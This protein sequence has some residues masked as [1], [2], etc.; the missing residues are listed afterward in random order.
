MTALRTTAA[1]ILLAVLTWET[2]SAAAITWSGLTWN[3]KS[4]T[5][6]GPGP[7]TWSAD[8]VFV[9]ASGDLHLAITSVGGSWTC[10]EIATTAAF[11]F[12]SY[13]WQV[14]TAVDNLDPN[15]VLGLFAYGP[16]ALGPDGTHEID[17]EYARFGS[18]DADNGRWTDWPN[19]IVTPSLV[20]RSSYPLQLGADPTT[21][22]RFTWAPTDI[23]FST[24]AGFQPP[25]ANASLIRSWTYRPDDP[26]QTISQ[27]PMPVHVNLWLNQGAPPT[28]GQGVEVVIHAFSF[29]PAPA[30]SVP[31][32]PGD[33]T[34]VLAATLIGIGWL[35]SRSARRSRAARL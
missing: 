13:Q 18:A 11:G 3:V 30:A 33:H 28:N 31:A 24:L 25:G 12:G 34:F 5:Q 20:A 17:I 7:N 35:V 8:N 19:I 15:V 2:P 14:R 27:S 32:L 16:L 23:T 26:S 6:M 22:S 9:D 4:G 29:T 10:A 21:T 1:A